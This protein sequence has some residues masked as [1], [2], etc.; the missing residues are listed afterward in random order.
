L[1]PSCSC[2]LLLHS[3]K[4]FVLLLQTSRPTPAAAAELQP[5]S[6]RK[7]QLQK[8]P[9]SAKKPSRHSPPSPIKGAGRPKKKEVTNIKGKAVKI[10]EVRKNW[11]GR[12]FLSLG[13]VDFVSLVREKGG[14][15][16]VRVSRRKGLKRDRGLFG[17][18]VVLR[19]LRSRVYVGV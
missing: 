4:D 7:K 16:V 3:C 6:S 12:K 13:R 5:A 10:V 2:S 15:S 17:R 1:S 8:A 19:R 18:S 9:P 14:L 11:F